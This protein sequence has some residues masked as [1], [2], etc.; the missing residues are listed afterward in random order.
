[1]LSGPY[2][3]TQWLKLPLLLSS[4]LQ[5]PVQR[6][7]QLVQR[8]TVCKILWLFMC[9]RLFTPF[10]KSWHSTDER[11]SVWISSP[12]VTGRSSSTNDLRLFKDCSAPSYLFAFAQNKKKMCL[13]LIQFSVSTMSTSSEECVS[14]IRA[15]TSPSFVYVENPLY[16]VHVLFIIMLIERRFNFYH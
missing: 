13:I 2:I 11:V 3:D 1:M 10:F 8:C 9:L 15:S 4:L 5:L 16:I 6:A 14:S 7:L 12:L